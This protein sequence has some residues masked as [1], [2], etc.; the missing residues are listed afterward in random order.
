[1]L[2][3]KREVKQNNAEDGKRGKGSI[4]ISAVWRL[5]LTEMFHYIF[6][7]NPVVHHLPQA[8]LGRNVLGNHN[9]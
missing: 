8:D 7:C 2:R 1:M 9:V 6:S 5:C 4:T 3:K